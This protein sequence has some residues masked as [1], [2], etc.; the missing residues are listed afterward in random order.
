MANS[1]SVADGE[2]DTMA[3]GLEGIVA[4]RMVA[5]NDASAA[6]AAAPDF[7]LVSSLLPQAA[8][9]AVSSSAANAPT[10]MRLDDTGADLLVVSRGG[11]VSTGG[12]SW[13]NFPSV[14]GVRHLQVQLTG[15]D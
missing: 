14:E 3:C 6:A 13:T 9:P 5:G 4:L 12:L 7:A 1:V 2:S 8:R 15:L 11:I 10:T